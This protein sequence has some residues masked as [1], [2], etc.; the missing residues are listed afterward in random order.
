[1]EVIASPDAFARATEAADYLR[2]ALQP[3]LQAPRIAVVCGSGLGGLQNTIQASPRLEIPYSQIPHFPRSTGM[4]Y[5]NPPVIKI[6]IPAER[7]VVS[8]R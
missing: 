2:A 3:E 6:N 4:L 8:P 7:G 5:P 1:M